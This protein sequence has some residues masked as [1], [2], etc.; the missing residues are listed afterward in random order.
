VTVAQYTRVADRW[1]ETY[2]DA[3]RYYARRAA[4]VL[5]LG[6]PLRPG[7]RVVDLACGDGG[8]AEPLL[9][10]GLSYIGVDANARMTEAAR[11]RLAS[12]VEVELADLNDYRPGE[13]VAATLCFRAIYYAADRRAFFKQVAGYTEK[14]LVF[15]LNPRQYSLAEVGDDLLRAGFDGFSLRPFF[16][17]QTR[18]LPRAMHSLLKVAESSGPLAR[19]LLRYRFSYICAAYRRGNPG[20]LH[21]Q[22]LPR[23]AGEL[24]QHSR[25]C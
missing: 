6:P 8:L 23:E 20:H 17:P 18:R 12:R 15:D 19:M 5:C 3:Q 2:A 25:R 21:D 16:M 7:D 11:R 9:A 24:D 13:P 1:S 14:K 4:V 22:P 10:R